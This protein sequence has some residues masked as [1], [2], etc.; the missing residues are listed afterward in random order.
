MP[1]G[2]PLDIDYHSHERVQTL[3]DTIRFCIED[4]S[5]SFDRWEE[6]YI[7]G[8][9]LYVAIFSGH[10]VRDHADPMGDNQWPVTDC[11]DVLEDVD[12]FYDA[13]SEV[14]RSRDGAVVVSVDGI[15]QEQMVRFRDSPSEPSETT[16]RSV[17]Y[18]D[19]MGARHMSAVE[20]SARPEVVTTIT[21]S[22]ESGRVTVF[23]DGE[24]ST[25]PRT[26]LYQAWK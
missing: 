18:A 14:A 6:P 10:T 17:Q 23:E 8:P 9:G 24:Y 12:A 1:S 11:R 13:T 26:D 22:A 4:I 25:T 7:T 2:N 21:L 15:V 3:V 16:Q 19:W 20:T 5:L